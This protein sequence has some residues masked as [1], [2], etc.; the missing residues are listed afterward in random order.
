MKKILL[1]LCALL[2]TVGAMATVTSVLTQ[3]T[4]VTSAAGLVDGNSYVFRVNGGS[5]IT[6]SGTQYVAPNAQNSIT[7]EAVFTL[8]DL[9]GTWFV[10][11]ESTTNFWGTL[12]SAAT[13]N[14]SPSGGDPGEWTFTFNGEN[15]SAESNGYYINR[16]SGVLHGWGTAINLQIYNVETVNRVGEVSDLRNDKLYT[17][18]TN[19]RGWWV[20]P[21]GNAAVTSTT[22]AGLATSAT[23]LKQQFAFVYYDDPEDDTNDGYYLYS[24]SEK[25]FISKSG[26]YTT[27]TAGPGDK[28]TLLAS[29]NSTDYPTVVAFN[30]SNQAGISNGY[31]PAIITHYNDLADDGNRCAIM[32]AGSFD[33]SEALAV[34]DSYF[35]PNYTVT[36]VVKDGSDNV[37]FTSE[38]VPTTSGANIT[39][40]PADY[41]LTN[42]YTYNTVD[43]TIT[44]S[45]N[46]DVE[47][48]ATP[49]ENPLVKYTADASNPYYYNLNIRSKYLVYNS[50][51]IGEVTLQNTS[52]PFNSDASWAFIGEPYAGFKVINK[53]KG[54]NYFLTYTSVVTGNNGGSDG[55]NNNVQFVAIEDF[56]NRY[57]LIDKNTGGFCMRMKENTNIYFHHQNIANSNGYLRTCSVS[58]WSAVHNDA[59]STIVASTDEDVLIALYNS[60]KD[61]SF[62]DAI[63]QYTAEGIS[64]ADANATISN[65]GMVI[66]NNM[67]S[68][69]ADAYA[70]LLD[71][72][73]ATTLN[74]PTA[75]FY[76]LK[77]V[78][79]GKYLTAIKATGF[80]STEYGVYANGDETSEAT[81]IKLV[82]KEGQLYMH[83]Q[84]C[85]FGWVIAD[86]AYGSG[87]AWANEN[88]WDKYVNW[89]PGNAAGQIGFAICY[90]NGAGSYASYL[91]RGIYTA[92]ADEAVIGGTDYTAD[93]AQWIVEP[94][95]DVTIALHA[96]GEKSYATTYL[97]FGV[98]LGGNVKAYVLTI[99]GDYAV[100]TE[101]GVNVP[102]GTPVLLVSETAEESV[103]ATINDEITPIDLANAL[104]GSYFASTPS[105]YVLN[106]VE[107]VP[108]FYTLNGT[109]AANRAYLPKS[110]SVK[111]Y[112]FN[113]GDAD[114]IK[115]IEADKA[116]GKTIYNL[117]GQRVENAQKGIF[118]VNGKKVVIK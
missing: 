80:A 108:G 67:T 10:Y 94:A 68:A 57:W 117:A 69:Y 22:K 101:Y 12:P 79:T 13:G 99:D 25:K 103:V 97:P 15:V 112:A 17:I 30:G 28:V 21:S 84:N 39:T 86:K 41:Q 49:K 65:V 4:K 110:S 81:V 16:S 64:A 89:F 83:N 90:G 20:V 75:G 72:Q 113:W 77:N 55:S 33:A 95:T 98:T 47:F 105:A 88:L 23:D 109:L 115:A 45:G 46:T 14:F 44:T 82:E 62:G 78:S 106:A 54:T 18:R 24:V 53:T 36:Y 29:Q 52:E 111:G 114:A 70:A 40:L 5:Y 59:G 38:A 116:A 43:V 63:G 56:N 42:F 100:P 58:E 34:I 87:N 102:A 85:S 6:E 71:I 74:T 91:T 48:I 35:H 60:M 9:G 96:V 8:S 73:A 37:L 1:L 31:N 118:I 93:A 2:G 32:E 61:I 51:A 66:D 92:N 3:G 7:A 11:N 107:S 50:E 104:Q 76:R 26:N 27:L 19:G